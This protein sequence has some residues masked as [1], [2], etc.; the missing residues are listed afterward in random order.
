MS[1]DLRPFFGSLTGAFFL[2][3]NRPTLFRIMC[4]EAWGFESPLPHSGFDGSAE[5]AASLSLSRTAVIS[6][7]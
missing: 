3:K 2:V 6:N 4:R 1:D 7:Q 5:L